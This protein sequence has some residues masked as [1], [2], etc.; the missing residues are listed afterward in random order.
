MSKS[1]NKDNNKKDSNLSINKDTAYKR[2]SSLGK[3]T[4]K[5]REEY[6]LMVGLNY[7]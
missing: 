4:K 2:G 1:I 6:E 3:L 7:T 5:E